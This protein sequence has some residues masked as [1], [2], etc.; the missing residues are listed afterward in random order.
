MQFIKAHFH[1][2]GCGHS[3]DIFF[4]PNPSIEEVLEKEECTS[5]G[6]LKY[7]YAGDLGYRTD[8]PD[9]H[10]K[11]WQP[12]FIKL[13]YDKYVCNDC[14]KDNPNPP[15]FNDIVAVCSKCE[16]GFMDLVMSEEVENEILEK[17]IKEVENSNKG[18]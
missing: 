18:M 13:P 15:N 8:C 11:S 6:E 12:Q 5:C 9:P 14:F 2:S 16:I 7:C 17:V 1:C 3:T 4:E 10:Y